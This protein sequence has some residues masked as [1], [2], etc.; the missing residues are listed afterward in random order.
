MDFQLWGWLQTNHTNSQ[1]FQK[2]RRDYKG[3]SNGDESP[4]RPTSKGPKAS[5]ST[6]S[7]TTPQKRGAAKKGS[8]ED[9]SAQDDDEDELL[10][11]AKRKRPMKPEDPEEQSA[12]VFKIEGEG[13]NGR[14]IDL[15]NDEYVF[16][17]QKKP[18]SK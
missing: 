5:K 18:T 13:R 9:S 17:F 1:H 12:P 3:P 6:T 10:H 14:A 15:V 11:S 4:S 2:I 16:P 7:K 8:F